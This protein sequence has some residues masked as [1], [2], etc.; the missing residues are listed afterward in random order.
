VH[1]ILTDAELLARVASGDDSAFAALYDRYAAA[2][3]GI[4]RR[5]LRDDRLAEDAVQEAFLAAWRTAGR[6][7]GSRA[8]VRA[9]L[10]TLTHRRAVDLVRRQERRRACPLPEEE[11]L[12]CG[13]DA[14]G[15]DVV[16]RDRV[17]RALRELP[18]HE[19]MVLELAYYEG[20]SQSEIAHALATPLGTVKSRTFSALARLRELLEPVEAEAPLP[21]R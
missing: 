2:A 16:E 11:Q 7:D 20:L 13:H 18:D 17:V 15:R 1:A 3:Y 4:A 9:W 8:S 12:G 14:E 10:V 21:A 19:R 5:V 6:Y